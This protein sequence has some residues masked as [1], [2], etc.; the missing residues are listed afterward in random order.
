MEYHIAIV[1]TFDIF[2]HVM[3]SSKN[4]PNNK[5]YALFIGR[6]Q[7]FHNG[8][9]YIIDKMIAKDK[10]VCIAIR[11]TKISDANPFTVSQREEMIRRIY[12]EKVKIITIPD[13]ESVNIGRNVGYEINLIK[14]PKKI[15]NISATAIRNGSAFSLPD[16]VSNYLSLFKKTIWFT[17]L[18]C[19][20]KTTIAKELKTELN[21]RGFNAVHLD[22]DELRKT[23]NSDLGYS[24][25]DRME[26]IR[27]IVH[28]AKLF[29][30]NNIPVVASFITPTNEMREM[31][32]NT[33]DNPFLVYT[34]CSLE[35][36][37]KRD[38]KG[39]YMK[40]IK[41]EL[42]YFTGVSAPF[43]NPKEVFTVDT[44]KHQAYECCLKI[45]KKL[46]YFD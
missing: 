39:M 14:V 23:I 1:V 40:A 33:L 12:G 29:N 32:K 36:C 43:E 18:P 4:N 13:I 41:G 25:E 46:D 8:H 44:E 7:P 37:K 22:A 3:K 42:G 45:M 17:G 24:D 15:S 2:S 28:I 11:D 34:K 26:N 31:V 16:E 10:E 5:P 21:K 20:G 30:Q 38:S 19:S 27:R 9:K 6:W 35:E